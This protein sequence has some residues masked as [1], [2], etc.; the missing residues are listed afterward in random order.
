MP[1]EEVQRI[2]VR[3]IEPNPFQP[4]TY[5]DDEKLDELAASIQQYGVIQPIVVRPVGLR[6]QVITGE[7]R[8]RAVKKLG[9][10]EI[11][12]IVRRYTDEQ[13]LEAALIENLQREDISVVEAARAY[14][15]LTNE[16]HYSQAEIAQRT[17]RSRAA[18]NNTLRLLQLPEKVLETVHK[19]DLTEGHAR[20][21]LSLPTAA[22]QEEL[23]EWVVRNGITVRETESKVR[24]LLG[25]AEPPA[26]K[27]A[28][29]AKE[30][31]EAKEKP[32]VDPHI[33]S[34]EQQLRDLFSTKV[35]VA[36]RSGRG[37]I[38]V[39]FYNDD[40]LGRLMDLLGLTGLDR[41]AESSSAN[42]ETAPETG[43]R[44]AETAT[45]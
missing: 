45:A 36:Y 18:I 42:G 37:A 23:A 20:A 4:R 44:D 28:Q 29:E 26:A 25:Q 12:A 8:L 41:P 31:K 43:F 30:A 22:I 33:A 13:A 24:S 10:G 3:L 1:A 35:S 19:G 16:F 17:G 2:A 7:R 15:R 34:I 14:T 27:E 38:T 6:F 21:L 39:E 11:P 40:D 5:F 32:A 9:L